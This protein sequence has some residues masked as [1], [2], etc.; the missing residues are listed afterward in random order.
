MNFND[1]KK[2][3]L[4]KEEELNTKDKTIITKM[5][6]NPIVDGRNA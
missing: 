6:D 3:P 4:Q 5:I 1:L 2:A